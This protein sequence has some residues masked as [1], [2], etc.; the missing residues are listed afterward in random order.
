MTS[1]TRLF[2]QRESGILTFMKTGDD[3]DARPSPREEDIVIGVDPVIEEYKKHVDRSVLIE[4]LRLTSDE[5]S[6]K[7]LRNMKL[8][9]ELLA[10]SQRKS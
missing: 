3:R 2:K 1:N 9:Y 8:A 4:N 5:R 6:W 10:S 7:F